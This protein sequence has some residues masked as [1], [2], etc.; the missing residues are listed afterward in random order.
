[1]LIKNSSECSKSELDIFTIPPTQTSIEEGVWDTIQPHPNF[2]DS[3]TIRFDI[4]KNDS[5]YIDLSETTLHLNLKIS[6]ISDKT[7]FTNDIKIA[8]V[9]NF[10]H[11][12]FEQVKVKLNDK[13]VENTNKT[14]AYRAYFESL[15]C[16]GKEAKS[17]FLA[18]QGWLKDTLI[19]FDTILLADTITG[20]VTSAYH[21]P[22]FKVR[23]EQFSDNKIVQLAGKLHC[24]IFN[25][26]KNLLNEV[27]V[28]ITLNRS[29]QRFHLMGETT[30]D[31]YTVYIENAFIKV[32]RNTISP[33]VMLAHAMAL[34]K[35]HAKYPIKRVIVKSIVI[36]YSAQ[37]CTVSLHNG[38]I[39]SR[40][41]LGLLKTSSCDG[42]YGENPFNFRNY[43]L[44]S[45]NLKAA[46]KSLPYS[47]PLT[48]DY[49]KGA[50]LNGYNTLF[51]SIR[52]SGN[53][54]TYEEYSQGNTIY[55]F[56]LSPDLCNSE[57]YSLIKSGALE[58]DL[59]FETSLTESITVMYYLE[60]DNIIEI[61]KER[62]VLIDYSI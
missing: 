61:T 18:N 46:S 41:V 45:I 26:N 11:S 29:K 47:T 21:N 48:L 38:I 60:F 1:M 22:G 49:T 58:L 25:I 35:T 7:G 56:D 13:D 59:N 40:V 55:A 17:T 10:I 15:L 39:P 3:N 23:N 51:Q 19:T 5:K 27:D 37:M 20:G 16:Y 42:N 32:R 62:E 54:I 50:Y 2:R 33:S 44:T 43:K 8:P 30:S 14:Y 4:P 53:D 36:P 24:D 6:K 28:S 57:H 52:E 12:L 34:E 9:N 31:E